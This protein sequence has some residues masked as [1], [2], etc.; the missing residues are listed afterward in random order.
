LFS[1]AYFFLG[2]L[3]LTLGGIGE[4]I[5]GNTFPAIVFTSFGGYWFTFGATLVPGYAAYASYATD[6]ANPASGMNPTFFASFAFFLVAMCMLCCVY[7]VAALRTNIAFFL[8]FLMLIPC[9]E[10]SC[11]TCK[12]I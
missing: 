6:P 8:I 1:G 5:L 12:E 9:C 10:Y 11:S 7:C 3:M 2:G 4:W